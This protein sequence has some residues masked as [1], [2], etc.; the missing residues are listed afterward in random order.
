MDAQ[1]HRRRVYSVSSNSSRQTCV[2]V[3]VALD[4]S[5]L[6]NTTPLKF[7]AY[8]FSIES[9]WSAGAVCSTAFPSSCST[10]CPSGGQVRWTA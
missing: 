6:A 9:L 8:E 5:S 1:A 3:T 4:C 2:A 7:V 10:A